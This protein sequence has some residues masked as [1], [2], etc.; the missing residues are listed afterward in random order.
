ERPQLGFLPLPLASETGFFYLTLL[1]FIVSAVALWVF[2]RSPVGYALKGVREN[3]ARMRALGYDVW[4]YKYFTSLVAAFFAGIAGQLFVALE[5]FLS[6]S[7]LGVTLSAQ[8]L[9]MVLVAA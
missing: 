4:R 1:F 2:V 9:M 3:E 5:C 7:A 6:P 8:A